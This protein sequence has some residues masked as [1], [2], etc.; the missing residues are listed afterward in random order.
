VSSSQPPVAMANRP[1]IGV[2]F[3]RDVP[4]ELLR[5]R[6]RLFE[7]VGLD[8]VWVV[9]DLCFAGGIATAATALAA[10]QRLG[11]GL[12]ILPAMV[13]NPLFAAMEIAALARL[14]PGRVLPGIGHGMQDWMAIAGARPESPLAALKEVLT[15]VSALLHGETVTVQGRYLH[16]NGAQLQFPPKERIP[17]LAGVRG[18]RSIRLAG[19]ACD[20]VIL[21]E[22][23]SPAYVR[24]ARELL[25]EAAAQAGR[26]RPTIVVYTWLSVAHDA[27]VAYE[28]VLPMLAS[29]PGGLSEPSVRGSLSALDFGSELIALIDG[30]TSQQQL[31]ASL[32]PE[33]V[34]ELSVTGTPQM[35]ANAIR[36]LANA[37]ADRVV[38]APLPDDVDEQVTLLG[39]EVLPLL[40]LAG[41]SCPG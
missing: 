5:Q 39:R 13:R 11:V 8:D 19:A 29:I 6:V 37:G 15:C 38:L 21:A 7:E 23:L 4:P 18:P 20:G 10:T 30:A 36:R 17:L 32:R 12:G 28:R 34:G 2:M 26:G 31:A 9:E 24:W 25:D 27:Q 3:E 22:P 41:A 16:L 35:C 33:W 14:Y 1:P 40:D